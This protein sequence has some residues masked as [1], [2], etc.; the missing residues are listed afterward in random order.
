MRIEEVEVYGSRVLVKKTNPYETATKAGLWIPDT[1]KQVANESHIQGEVIKVGE[2]CTDVKVGDHV[3]WE[4]YAG[5]EMQFE[6]GAYH[7]IL[8]SHI[9]L[10]DNGALA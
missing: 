4:R 6:E 9:E 5:G 2:E 10:I 1:A 8:E 3:Y 7:I